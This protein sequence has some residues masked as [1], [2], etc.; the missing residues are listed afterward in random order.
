MSLKNDIFH[1]AV[2]GGSGSDNTREVARRSAAHFSAWAG[3]NG[4]KGKALFCT[5]GVAAQ[6]LQEYADHMVAKGLS[7]AT[8]HTRLAAPCKALGVGMDA[9]NKPARTSGA[10]TRSRG[11]GNAQGHKQATDPKNARLVAF[12]RAVGVRRAELSKLRGRDLVRDESGTL[13]VRVMRGKGGKP[14]LQRI[15]PQNEATVTTIMQENGANKLVFTKEEL[16]NKI[17]LHGIRAEAARAAYDHYAAKLAVD[18]A[19]RD[20]LRT[21]LLARWDAERP[22]ASPSQ[23]RTYIDNL[24]NE[25]QLYLRKGGENYAQAVEHDRPVVYDRLAV[26]AVSVFHLSHWR[27]DVT[28]THYLV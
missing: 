11:L 12:Q 18:S 21:E 6:A 2:S 22:D 7:P 17:D 15:L 14:Q 16:N 25:H 4:Y 13:C 8:V 20:Q 19:Y 9:I 5:P 26:M 28:V 27:T 1:R 23:R 10:V 24:H 3:A